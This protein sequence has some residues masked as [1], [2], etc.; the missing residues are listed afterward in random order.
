[1]FKGIEGNIENVE[2]QIKNLGE[3]FIDN[4]EKN[5]NV[6]IPN[7]V[8]EKMSAE[9][10][11]GKLENS[12]KI[13]RESEVEVKE[14][15]PNYED[16]EEWQINCQRCVPTFEVRMRGF[17]VEAQP[18][19]YNDEFDDNALCYQPFA[20]YDNPEIVN[21]EGNG[22]EDIKNQMAEWGDGSR[23]EVCVMWDK[24]S[25][26]GGGHVFVAEQVDG[27]TRFLDPQNGEVDASYY[28]DNVEAGSVQL[29]RTDN[30]KINYR[31]EECCTPKISLDD[32]NA[33][34]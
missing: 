20:V 1:M 23:A 30:A 19:D 26:G 16:G 6:E 11:L 8:K 18:F 15:N 27:E 31:I 12:V 2:S 24:L 33:M 21:C 17:D 9:N 3:S 4:L 28:F 14:V 13:E 22:I 29:C 10:Y 32:L 5:T 7:S 34:V 25:T